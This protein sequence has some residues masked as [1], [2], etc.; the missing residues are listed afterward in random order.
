MV[1]L[2]DSVANG[3]PVGSL[4]LLEGPQRFGTKR[5]DGVA[6]AADR[7]NIRYYLLDGQQRV[8]SLLHLLQD[9]GDTQYFVDLRAPD[10]KLDEEGLP[11]VQ[12]RKRGKR[13][14][15]NSTWAVN[16]LLRP[17]SY[18]KWHDLSEADRQLL[19]TLREQRLGELVHGGYTLPAIVM[20]EDI[21]L[22]ALTRIFETLNRTGTR[23]DAFDLMVAV[24]YN[25]GRDLREEWDEARRHHP[26]LAKE[27]FDV[28][29]I[30]I[31]KLVA[32]WKRDEDRSP[33]SIRPPSR[34]V[35]GV[36]QK[37][38]LNVPA[39]YV[40]TRWDD[41]VEAY[42]GALELLRKRF[43]VSLP[44]DVP[45]WAMV[46]V[47]AYFVGASNEIGIAS[48]VNDI[49]RWYWFSVAMQ[50]YAQGANT[51]VTY[52]VDHR[53]EFSD[54]RLVPD[55]V[56]ASLVDDSR[57]NRLLR[58]GLKSAASVVGVRD[59]LTG[60][61]LVG[62]SVAEICVSDDGS[63]RT[64]VK[65]NDLLVEIGYVS[66][67]SLLQLGQRNGD[68]SV[69]DLHPEAL[70]GQGFGEDVT[71]LEAANIRLEWLRACAGS[72]E[73]ERPE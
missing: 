28:E 31:L 54:G 16:E 26:I 50:T 2:L 67:S 68:V 43:G 6:Q 20:R 11:P 64:A 25:E 57:R 42:V 73:Y 39:D 1:E 27:N 52:D 33:E 14:P 3:W 19:M 70:A 44:E 15:P 55:L 58:R 32:L 8:T 4:L 22:E 66:E 38:V 72:S 24:V 9:V 60:R 35:Q 37:D 29:P 62:E 40:V 61:S 51:Q 41:A 59:L 71:N 12:W 49:Q 34:R 23:L 36:R 53:L 63:V 56:L 21:D 13:T 46:L 7:E 30:E 65:S 18:E 48:R 47:V 10:E 45:S 17:K 5:M 69:I